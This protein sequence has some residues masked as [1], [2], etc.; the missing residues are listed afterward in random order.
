MIALFPEIVNGLS[1]TDIWQGPKYFSVHVISRIEK[2]FW[3]F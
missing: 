1:T 2:E 3:G